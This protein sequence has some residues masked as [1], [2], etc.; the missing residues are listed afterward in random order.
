M[1]VLPHPPA[2]E[3][4]T[5]RTSTRPS[6]ESARLYW[7]MALCA[8]ACRPRA[9]A[10]TCRPGLMPRT[11]PRPFAHSLP[12][13]KNTHTHTPHPYSATLRATVKLSGSLNPKP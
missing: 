5:F 6:T 10:S 3:G 8:G 13:Q 2:V 9:T 7:H 4:G 1:L 11:A 12:V